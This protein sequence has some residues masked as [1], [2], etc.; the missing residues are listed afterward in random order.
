MAHT[1]RQYKHVHTHTHMY[2]QCTYSLT[3][4]WCVAVQVWHAV[5][6]YML[7]ALLVVY[8]HH[9]DNDWNNL[10]T[11]GLEEAQEKVCSLFSPPS[12]S[13]S[14]SAISCLDDIYYIAADS[15]IN[16]LLNR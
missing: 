14:F 10:V 7:E 12:L 16:L 6:V 11:R 13:L 1:V 4:V 15:M 3:C 9:M 8:G 2:V 5:R